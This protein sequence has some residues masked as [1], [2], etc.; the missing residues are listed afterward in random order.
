MKAPGK[1]HREGISLIELTEMF[2]DE[3]SAVRWWE[4]VRWPSGRFCGHCGST[5]TKEVPNAKPMPYWC[6]G[7]KSYFSVRT[8]SMIENSRLPL[9]KWAF[10]TYL[11]VTSLK[12]V[13]S[14]KLHRD[15]KV[16][17]KTAWFMLH[18]LRDAWGDSSSAPFS[19]PVEADET[20][21]GGKRKNMPKAKRKELKGRGAVGKAVVV[22]TKD[23]ETNRV[24]ARTV[25]NTDGATL[26]GFVG[27]HA[28]PGAKVYTDEASAYQGM[29]FDHEAV[30]HS[31]GEYV[32]GMAHT[33]GIESFWAMLKRGYHGTYHHM[34]EKHL[35]R[36]V[37]EFSGRH[38][39]READTI[40]QMDN[41]VAA[42]VGKRLMY[43]D[44][45]A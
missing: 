30:N 11:Y 20:Y 2:P 41:L 32:R 37:A 26:K 12:G 35:D 18:R 43:R 7:C 45:I 21:I 38:N 17:Q 14:M 31:A 34:S 39:V 6:K 28:A 25:E 9:R 5:E 19:G 13:S 1:S 29:P 16:T 40:D 36:Y 33:N 23:R 24:A 10:A 15:L 44:L 4:S 8:G 22:G 27:E 3:A 42:T